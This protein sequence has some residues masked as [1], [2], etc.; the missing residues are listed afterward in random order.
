MPPC[1]WHASQEVHAAL[2]NRLYLTHSCPALC[3]VT[4]AASAAAV[5]FTLA[6]TLLQPRSVALNLAK[7]LASSPRPPQ[8]VQ[9][10]VQPR[11]GTPT[12]SQTLLARSVH[13][14][15][16]KQHNEGHT[17]KNAWS[18]PLSNVLLK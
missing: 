8:Q 12:K 3:L 1:G 11:R 18:T 16:L 9:R 7:A 14:Q 15:G 10:A 4:R 17:N 13:W 2:G 5:R 6:Y